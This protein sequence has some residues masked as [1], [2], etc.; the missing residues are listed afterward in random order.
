MTD[1]T[2]PETAPRVVVVN[3]DATQLNVMAGLLK[4]DGLATEAFTAAE[5]ALAAMDREGPPDLV[6]TDLYMPDL[7][8]WRF[9]RL[10]RSPAHADLN[11]VPILVVSATFSGD[12]TARITAD[13]GANA[14]LPAPVDGR[15]FIGMVRALL[16]GEQPADF[17]R[18]LIVEDDAALA[19]D[20]KQAFRIHGYGADTAP[21]AEAGRQKFDAA[22]YDVA[23]IDY[24][25]PDGLGDALLTAF[26][27]RRPGCVFVMM[28]NDPRP[29][30]ALDWMKKGAAA[31]LRKPFQ[32][33]YL[34]EVCARA[35]RE[36][37]LLR[38]EDL[39][40][41]RTRELRENEERYRLLF[42]SMDSGLALHEII[43]DAAGAPRDYRF[44][45]VNPAFEALMGLSA[46]AV[47][48]RTAREVLPNV[49]PDWIDLCGRVALTGEP[50]HL[51]RYCAG[52]NKHLAVTAYSPQPGRFVAIF[53]DITERKRAEAERLA[54]ERRLQQA[55]KAESL[56]RMAGAIAHHFNNQIGAVMGNLELALEDVPP[57][58]LVRKRMSDAMAAADRAAE[59][60]RL[61]LAYRGQIA[62]KPEARDLAGIIRDTLP[63]AR[64]TLPKTVD[65]KADLPGVGPD[66]R[67]DA[68]QLGQVLTHLVENAGEAIGDERGEIRI[69][70]ETLPASAVE[71]AR[72]FPVDWAPPSDPLAC[73]TVSDTGC[74]VADDGID[75]LF[76][77]YFTTRETT[78]GLGLAVVLG[79]VTGHGGAVA[80]ESQLG[81]GTIF[82][83]LLP[84]REKPSAPAGKRA[85]AETPFK[86]GGAVLLVEDQA[87][88][89]E[90]TQAMLERLGFS[91]VAAEN[92]AEAVKR[93][94]DHGEAIR[95][96][97]CDL[98]MPGMNG[99][100]TLRALRTIRPDLPAV[101]AS[102]YDEAQVMSA[103]RDELNLAQAFVFK[104]Y[105]KA[106]LRKALVRALG[107]AEQPLA[108][109]T[110]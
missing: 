67:A 57:E 86:G 76:D 11:R 71:T 73:L 16:G 33:E 68:A 54:L 109:R 9:C 39:L 101:L 20:L 84:L 88:V 56:A 97:I 62:G 45:E 34:I 69:R 26:R 95:C 98:T 6:V 55:R 44:L 92:G 77:P 28:T 2:L 52:L 7:D 106:D 65:L 83:V 80:V 85:A 47:T 5:A 99:W 110:D 60:S 75:Q 59:V 22:D 78:R 48:G 3:D 103:D 63:V 10:L 64:G 89:R 90:V 49:A 82:R 46:E 23:V 58:G 87:P 53:T 81:R 38:V 100:E 50:L 30:L 14:F 15:R 105:Q 42:T 31:F 93:F 61:M 21:T 102:G 91:V 66:V 35:R 24:H 72:L 18:C 108:K 51:E 29:S 32:P 104:P 40:E 19:G 1:A 25:L 41:Q 4:K 79:T 96:V 17:L 36:R 37:A 74:G 13:L 12:E 70:V 27:T 8:G 43:R 94:S 107:A